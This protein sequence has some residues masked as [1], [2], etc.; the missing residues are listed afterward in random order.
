METYTYAFSSD[1]G[2]EQLRNIKYISKEPEITPD[3]KKGYCLTLDNVPLVFMA[4]MQWAWEYRG[5]Y[6]HFLSV[7]PAFS[8]CSAAATSAATPTFAVWRFAA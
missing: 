2:E 6:K 1:E 4:Y 8:A 3:G 5:C 7:A